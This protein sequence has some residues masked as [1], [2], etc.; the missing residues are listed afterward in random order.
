MLISTFSFSS[1]KGEGTHR[2]DFPVCCF[3][4]GKTAEGHPFTSYI[5]GVPPN[6]AASESSWHFRGIL[7]HT[8]RTLLYVT[9]QNSSVL[10]YKEIKQVIFVF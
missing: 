1:S 2:G 7:K 5:P 3:S 9:H 8:D 10:N 6:P 4:L